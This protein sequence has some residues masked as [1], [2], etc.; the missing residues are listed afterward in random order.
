MTVSSLYHCY[1]YYDRVMSVLRL[2]CY[3]SIVMTALLLY[4]SII[5]VLWLHQAVLRQ[6]YGSVMASYGG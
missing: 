6:L 3:D 1:C 2:K 4:D 5:A